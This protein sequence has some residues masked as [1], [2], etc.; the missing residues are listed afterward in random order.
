VHE[1]TYNADQKHSS[2]EEVMFSTGTEDEDD[3][4]DPH[5]ASLQEDSTSDKDD[6]EKEKKC[7]VGIRCKRALISLSVHE[8]EFV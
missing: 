4:C 7:Q 1:S 2:Q 8:K 6:D 5:W 3:E